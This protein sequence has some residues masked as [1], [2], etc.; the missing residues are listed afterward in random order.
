MFFRFKL[1][2][3]FFRCLYVVFVCLQSDLELFGVARRPLGSWNFVGVI[4]LVSCPL[5]VFVVLC[6][7]VVVVVTN[8]LCLILVNGC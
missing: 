8:C 3:V 1:F 4:V 5:F 6:V 7:F 2:C